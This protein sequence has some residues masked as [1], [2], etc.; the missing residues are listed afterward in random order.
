MVE[1][2]PCFTCS[3]LGSETVLLATMQNFL[4]NSTEAHIYG[5]SATNQLIEQ[6]WSGYGQIRQGDYFKEKLHMLL[7]HGMY[8]ENNSTC[9]WKPM[10]KNSPCKSIYLCIGK[11]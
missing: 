4:S 2:Y 1:I 10:R 8:D 5:T 9:R 3:D 6:W 7:Q 11:S